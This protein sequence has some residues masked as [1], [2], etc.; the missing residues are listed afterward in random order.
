MKTNNTTNIQFD[1]INISS[2]KSIV[3]MYQNKIND[4]VNSEARSLQLENNFGLPLSVA[5]FENR[6]VGYAFVV[7]NK[8]GET[9]INS[10]WEKDFYSIEVEKDLKFHA[11]NTFNTTF[12]DP[13]FRNIKLQ[14]ATQRLFNWLNYCN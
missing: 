10:Y 7:I 11:E 14:N 1:Q 8:V 6:V 9:E 12:K 4:T 2:L 13:E 5:S 3:N